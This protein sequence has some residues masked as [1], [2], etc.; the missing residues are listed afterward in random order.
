MYAHASKVI[1]VHVQE[2]KLLHICLH[3]WSVVAFAGSKFFDG[4]QYLIDTGI[5]NPEAVLG[6]PLLNKYK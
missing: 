2:V 5:N 1:S 6:L 3:L 4:S